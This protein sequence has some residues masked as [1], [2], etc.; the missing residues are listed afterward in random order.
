MKVKTKHST[1][2]RN[3]EEN[4]SLYKQWFAFACKNVDD[5]FLYSFT[6]FLPLLFLASIVL[7]AHIQRKH[8]RIVKN[9]IV[10]LTAMCNSSETCMVLLF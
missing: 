6:V 9:N 2:V 7:P 1:R 8:G 3:L 5:I 4:T 10:T